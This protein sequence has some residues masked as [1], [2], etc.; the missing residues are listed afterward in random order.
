MVIGRGREKW[1]LCGRTAFNRI[2]CAVAYATII[3]ALW[4]L[5]LRKTAVRATPFTTGTSVRFFS[6]HFSHSETATQFFYRAQKNVAYN[7]TLCEIRNQTIDNNK[8][9]II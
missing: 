5:G 6:A 7:G 9:I 8:I 1:Y 3:R 2:V 4:R